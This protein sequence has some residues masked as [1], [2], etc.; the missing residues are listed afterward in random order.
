[1]DTG[2][3]IGPIYVPAQS[4]RAQAEAGNASATSSL[5]STA[6]TDTI[7]ISEFS[8][9]TSVEDYLPQSRPKV[10]TK[11]NFKSMKEYIAY[12]LMLYDKIDK[13][14][15]MGGNQYV[16]LEDKNQLDKLENE[17]NDLTTG[18]TV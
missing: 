17:F 5:V 8:V 7:D 12:M 18:W 15:P 14:K 10:D 6:I 13:L 11:K 3:H 2:L 1:M 9:T 4:G 16:K